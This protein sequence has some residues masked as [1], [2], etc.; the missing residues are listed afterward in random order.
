MRVVVAIGVPSTSSG[1]ALRL[2]LPL[3][4]GSRS[5]RM[6]KNKWMTLVIYE[7]AADGEK[8]VQDAD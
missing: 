7:F 1:Q 3:Y 6:N 8:M 5:L 4:L 2:A